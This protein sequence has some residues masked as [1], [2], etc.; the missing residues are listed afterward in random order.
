MGCQQTFFKDASK[1]VFLSG[2]CRRKGQTFPF[3]Q[4]SQ[5]PLRP[6]LQNITLQPVGAGRNEV[7]YSDDTNSEYSSHGKQYD[8]FDVDSESESDTEPDEDLEDV[9]DE[10]HDKLDNIIELRG[11]FRGS[12]SLSR[13]GVLTDNIRVGWGWGS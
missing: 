9:V 10:L 4:P 5:I 11:K 12:L 3:Q 6:S 8:F 1:S 2:L 7:P 13:L